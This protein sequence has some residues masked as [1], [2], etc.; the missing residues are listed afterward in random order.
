MAQRDYV[1][2][3][4]HSAFSLGD[5]ASTPESLAARAA[6]LGYTALA[7]T[8]HDDLGGAVRFAKG[9]ERSGILPIF[10]A[11]ITLAD[12]SHLTLLVENPAGWAHLC[13][14]LSRARMESPRGAPGVAFDDLAGHAA[15]LV[16]L[17]GCPR[18]R[19]PRLLARERYAEA[20]AEA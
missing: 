15:G 4:A 10:G 19:I 16:A 3:H 1:E 2:L 11:E 9:C 5:G 20:R 7:L 18:G 14:L 6:E 8:D 12:G 13:A 17:G